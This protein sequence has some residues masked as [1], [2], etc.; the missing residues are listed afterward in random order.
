MAE[1]QTFSADELLRLFLDAPS[2]AESAKFSGLL[3][4][5]YALPLIEKILA[6]KFGDAGKDSMFS[7]QDYEDLRGDCCLKIVAV[8]HA[9]KIPANAARPI[10]DFAAY[11]AAIVYNDWNAF[12]REH[13][14][15]RENLKNK[16]RYALDKDGRFTFADDGDG[17]VFYRLPERNPPSPGISVERLTALVKVE[18]KFFAAADLP[19][20]LALIFEK[21]SGSL[22]I[23]QIV[24]VVADLWQVR[25]FPAI[26]LDYWHERNAPPLVRREN[27]EVRCRLEYVWR[28]IRALPILQRNALLYNLRDERGGEM[29]LMFFNARIAA[30]AEL[31]EA[32]NLTAV[33]FAELLP[34]LPFD[35]RKIAAVM[36]LS[37]KQIGNLRK[38]A[39]D[40][41][42]R[43]L[44]GKAQRKSAARA[45]EIFNFIADDLNDAATAGE[46][47][48]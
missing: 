31:A 3:I 36:N 14:P 26:S 44:D 48:N 17:K 42:R 18:N 41:L 20:L 45:A 28:E 25:D 22:K 34:H 6:A 35:D 7:A 39:R 8:L 21:A 40:N 47:L 15:Q 33:Q 13:S 12:V 10:K 29:L 4:E 16:I 37:V 38:T 24:K 5:N 27:Y 11:C 30:L 32:L 46:F 9:R 2:E 1:N 19:D 43:R 23:E